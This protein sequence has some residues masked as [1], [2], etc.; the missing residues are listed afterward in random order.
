MRPTLLRIALLCLLGGAV[1]GQ[2]RE[3]TVE[4]RVQE[5]V[6]SA[7]SPAEGGRAANQLARLG[8]EALA[9]IFAQLQS[10]EAQGGVRRAALLGAVGQ[11]PRDAVLAFLGGLVGPSTSEPGRIAALDLLARLGSRSELRLAI[12]LAAPV[13]EE[14]PIAPSRRQALQ[15]ALVGIR[16]RDPG[17]GREL[18]AYF[19]RVDAS[20]QAAIAEAI[21]A[22]RGQDAVS[23][24]AELLGRG[25]PGA[26]AL[27]LSTLG[28]TAGSLLEPDLLVFDRVRGYLGHPDKNLAVLACTATRHL[29][30]DGAVPDLIVLLCEE[31]PSVRRSAH[32][33]LTELTGLN[34]KP[35]AE[36]WTRW[37]DES[38][39]W[40]DER[41]DACRVALV[42][43]TPAE[44][45]AALHEVARQRLFLHD[46][47]RLIALALQ[48]GEDDLL[49]AGCRA[50]RS[51]PSS[52]A[53]AALLSLSKLPDSEVVSSARTALARSERPR[54]SSAR[55]LA[56]PRSKTLSP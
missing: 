8:L 24:L 22:G 25:G 10:D 30:D 2:E 12:E 52:A 11:L 7:Q 44:A 1:A 39:A 6:Q 47:V 20:I 18:V 46:V 34:L 4:E 33:A 45:A 29:V 35:V 50:L 42:S 40:W 56:F 49:Q 41:A 51:L 13:G 3:P 53:R 55:A 28:S 9:P 16:S 17:A 48:R 15:D 23:L 26:D 43:G 38:L 27:L 54:T 14:G 36:D 37:L 31:N 19:P 21:G 32:A 5:I